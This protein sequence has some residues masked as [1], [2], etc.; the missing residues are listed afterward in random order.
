MWSDLEKLLIW[1]MFIDWKGV[2]GFPIS[3]EP[4]QVIGYYVFEPFLIFDFYMKFL[5]QKNSPN[6][7]WLCIEF[8]QEVLK[9]KVVGKAIRLSMI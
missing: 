8:T 5:Q 9:Y 7:S 3:R 6:E 2:F 1:K 4:W